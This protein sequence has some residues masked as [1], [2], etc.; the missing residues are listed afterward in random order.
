MFFPTENPT[1]LMRRAL[2]AIWFLVLVG[3]SRGEPDQNLHFARNGEMLLR[4]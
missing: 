2:C 4:L 3:C 1:M